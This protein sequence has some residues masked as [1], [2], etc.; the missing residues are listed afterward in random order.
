MKVPAGFSTCRQARSMDDKELLRYSR[1]I[2][3][4][5]IGIEGQERFGSARVLVVGAGG[6]GC[7][8]ALYL[9]ASG[10]GRLI[11]VDDDTVDL[12]N[13]QR[14]VAHTTAGVGQSKVDSLGSAVAAI[15]PLVTLQLERRRVDAEWLAELLPDTDMVLDCTD[16]F[17]TRQLINRACFHAA[18]PLV[19]GAA[20]GF[21]GQVALFD[22]RQN[23]SPCYACV[24]PPD[25]AIEEVA[26]STMG[27]FAPLVGMVGTTQAAIALQVV[28]RDDGTAVPISAAAHPGML[29]MVDATTMEWSQM[30]LARDPECPV[31]SDR[32][33]GQGG[34]A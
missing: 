24:F 21:D 3:L 22:T 27:V 25:A 4:D 5:A 16:N 15:N 33:A 1:H 32:P 29:R 14:Q 34:V 8:A 17:G 26:C 20:L 2:L 23:S 31:C 10:V 28:L 11:L 30:R 18:K 13:L 19:S 7:A 12:T 9:G 6:L